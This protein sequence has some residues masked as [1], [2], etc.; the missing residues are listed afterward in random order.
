[1]LCPQRGFLAKSSDSAVED[2][3]EIKESEMKEDHMFSYLVMLL[4]VITAPLAASA[5][6][7]DNGEYVEV[8]KGTKLCSNIILNKSKGMVEPGRIYWRVMSHVRANGTQSVTAFALET[9][10]DRKSGETT[11][12]EHLYDEDYAT[13]FK[14]EPE[15]K[16]M[17]VMV[18]PRDGRYDA[19]VE[20]CKRK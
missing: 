18:S 2:Q 3:L 19:I 4:I 15:H 8:A 7:V 11:I 13:F 10:Y 1:M 12:V 6:F 16:G 14:R 17:L 9:V 5:Q 20:V